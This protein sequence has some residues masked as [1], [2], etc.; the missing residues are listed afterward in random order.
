MIVEPRPAPSRTTSTLPL[1]GVA[2]TAD[3]TLGTKPVVTAS[4]LAMPVPQWFLIKTGSQAPSANAFTYVLSL[5][6]TCAGS[7]RESGLHESSE[8]A[9]WVPP[10]SFPT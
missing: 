8:P 3:G 10:D 2:V 5:A 6:S 9:T 7:A 1:C 4:A